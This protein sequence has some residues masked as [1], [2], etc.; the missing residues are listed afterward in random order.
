MEMGDTRKMLKNHD[1][2]GTNIIPY[3]IEG[4]GAF[5]INTR[6]DWDIAELALEEGGIPIPESLK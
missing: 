6:R 5:D 2:A 1:I 4:P 3:K